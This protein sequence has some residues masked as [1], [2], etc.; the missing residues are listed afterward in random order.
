VQVTEIKLYIAELL[1]DIQL[2]GNA[3]VLLDFDK[4]HPEII[5]G[6]VKQWIAEKPWSHNYEPLVLL[7]RHSPTVLKL[8][9]RDKLEGGGKITAA[10]F[11]KTPDQVPH[12]NDVYPLDI[13]MYA[14]RTDMMNYDAL[15]PLTNAIFLGKIAI[16]PEFKKFQEGVRDFIK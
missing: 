8:M 7:A 3:R 15:E 6:F 13:C 1:K 9:Y 5:P 4:A 2:S 12:Y 14:M 16:M 10:V 11:G